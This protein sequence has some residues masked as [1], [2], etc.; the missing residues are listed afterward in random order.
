VRQRAG[1]ELEAG[2]EHRRS[3]ASLAWAK[4]DRW[5]STVG[6]RVTTAVLLDDR[7]LVRDHSALPGPTGFD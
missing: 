5:A 1:P 6:L 3:A 4:C 7:E 2:P